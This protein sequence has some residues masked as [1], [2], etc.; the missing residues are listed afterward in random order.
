MIRLSVKY[1]ASPLI[2]L[3]IAKH[4]LLLFVAAVVFAGSLITSYH[5]H[6][7]LQMRTSSCAVCKSAQQL[8]AG[9][10]QDSFAPVPDEPEVIAYLN[11]GTVIFIDLV[12]LPGQTRAPPHS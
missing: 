11:I 8:A 6:D 1:K 12:I 4:I 3:M 2:M 10:T 9:E 5:Y 7:D